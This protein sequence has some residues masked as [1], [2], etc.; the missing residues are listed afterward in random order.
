M[1]AL[2][3]DNHLYVSNNLLSEL[4]KDILSIRAVNNFP[5]DMKI[6]FE[7]KLRQL[8]FELNSFLEKVTEEYNFSKKEFSD[9]IFNLRTCIASSQSGLDSFE[10]YYLTFYYITFNILMAFV[11]IIGL[12]DIPLIVKYNNCP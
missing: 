7:E 5:K 10:E 1:L 3:L 8:N 4:N 12:S 9:L 2:D 11:Y 6:I